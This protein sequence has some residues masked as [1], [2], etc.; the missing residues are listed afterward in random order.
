[1]QTMPAPAKE[2]EDV[3]AMYGG[4]PGEELELRCH[5]ASP[6]MLFDLLSSLDPKSIDHK[7][8]ID[9]VEYG[10]DS[11][12]CVRVDYDTKQKQPY[13]K[14]RRATA[15]L[16][17]P[18]TSIV[19]SDE[20]PMSLDDLR[21]RFLRVVLKH[22]FS[23]KPASH[24]SWQMDLDVSR[25]IDTQE[26]DLKP[27]LREFFDEAPDIESLRAMVSRC[28]SIYEL[29]IEMEHV[30]AAAAVASTTGGSQ[31][32][33]QRG[34]P[35]ISGGDIERMME[36]VISSTAPKTSSRDLY[37]A[38]LKDIAR[39]FETDERIISSY[40]RG[41]SLRWMLPQVRDLSKQDYIDMFP[42]TK[43]MATE[44]ADGIRCLAS[45]RNGRLILLHKE[46]EEHSIRYNAERT[47]VEG[48][49]IELRDKSRLLLL[50]DVLVFDGESS[51]MMTL[52]S[53]IPKLKSAAAAITCDSL[54]LKAIA[55]EY[56]ALTNP[57]KYSK[58]FDDIYK[59][60]RDYKVDGIILAQR[61]APYMRTITYKWKPRDEQTI[62]LLIRRAPHFLMGTHPFMPQEGKTLYILF[63]GMSQGE[64][65][66]WN[67]PYIKGYG[68]LF[69]KD[70]M[71]GVDR[72]PMA[73]TM[74]LFPLSYLFWSSDT[75]LDGKI[76]EM[77]IEK[78]VSY[79]IESPGRKMRVLSW[80]VRRIRED[81]EFILGEYYGNSFTT[82]YN[83][84]LNHIDE[85]PLETLSTGVL[86]DVYFIESKSQIYQ[87][88][89]GYISFFK[90]KVIKGLDS[91]DSVL[92]LSSGKG[93][94]LERYVRN[95]IKELAVC[96]IDKAAIVQLLKRW[97]G[98]FSRGGIH[99][100]G[101]S[102]Q[103]FIFDARQPYTESMKVLGMRFD[104]MVCNLAVHYF[105]E[106][107]ASA[108][109]FALLCREAVRDGG[110]VNLTCMFGDKVFEL[111]KG[112]DIELLQD[113]IVKYSIKKMYTDDKLLPFGQKIGIMLPFS[114][115]IHFQEFLVN[116]DA[117]SE[118]MK[119][120]GFELI[121]KKGSL[122]FMDEFRHHN[123]Q[124][125]ALLTPQDMIHVGLYGM[126]KYR[127]L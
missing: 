7:R 92:D 6:D 101:T 77:G 23:S 98:F 102:L 100:M 85:F 80:E 15:K 17:L 32:Q 9:A 75:S 33:R 45:M 74:P 83:I 94:D 108:K 106:S 24:P 71:T 18:K 114:K 88:P 54:K 72:V 10:P 1:M 115:G 49:L 57:D 48:E 127:K 55:K 63:C 86:S 76:A 64:K 70:S 67:I 103:A 124:I 20:M 56:V 40:A 22:R 110:T 79:L 113:E 99:R 82:A 61:D 29:S 73:F 31:G 91:K 89:T 28:P 41:N 14:V 38:E 58:I 46:Y 105:L 34:R 39:C 11:K 59:T 4:S 112:G 93:Q 50:F 104:N 13:L 123:P 3:I 30:P 78:G 35:K 116:V 68:T 52:E 51:V 62:D 109:N 8:Y 12:A 25:A 120:G 27:I 65:R 126:L 81:K 119:E 19:L 111:L 87:A 44:K 5:V 21:S 107:A 117:L 47:V 122:E 60:K 37:V 118:A 53:R 84:L 26:M 69:G 42:P 125:H 2:I 36:S 16:R 95:G 66:A 43:Y 90:N 96:D 97:M 121:E